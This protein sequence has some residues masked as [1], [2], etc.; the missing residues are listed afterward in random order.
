M[1]I[2]I[3]SDV[4]KAKSLLEM[5]KITL[6]R[7]KETDF[8]KYPANTLTDYYDSI[9]KIMEALC[10][11]EGIKIKGEGAHQEL[12]D[13]VSKKYGLGESIRIFIQEMRE[14]RNRISYEGFMVK[15]D[16]ITRNISRIEKIIKILKSHAGI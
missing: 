13:Y 3:H 14:F 10:F 8:R 6:A 16:Y 1:I 2:K 12:I 15:E 7:L 11:I 4:E 9:H 5:S